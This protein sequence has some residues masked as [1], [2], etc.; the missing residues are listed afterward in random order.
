[1][2]ICKSKFHKLVLSL[3]IITAICFKTNK[4]KFK[5]IKYKLQHLILK[6]FEKMADRLVSQ[7]KIYQK[8][9]SK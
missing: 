7:G 4:N 9:M 2:S 3:N 5:I 1:M 8:K 6:I